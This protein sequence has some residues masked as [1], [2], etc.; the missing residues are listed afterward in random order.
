MGSRHSV[1]QTEQSIS[2]HYL[3]PQSDAGADNALIRRLVRLQHVVH[4][5][6]RSPV[7]QSTPLSAPR[8][9]F[10]CLERPSAA[11]L[12]NLIIS[13]FSAGVRLPSPPQAHFLVLAPR[14]TSSKVEETLK[15]NGLTVYTT[16]FIEKDETHELTPSTRCGIKNFCNLGSSAFQHE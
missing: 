9:D 7:L 16:C 15:N 10:G 4:T 1:D 6:P 11:T 8:G 5:L 14:D 12:S 3:Q 13:A 2:C